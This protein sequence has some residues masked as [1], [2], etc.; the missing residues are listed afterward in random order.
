MNR[1]VGCKIDLKGRV[2]K[3]KE[4]L[5]VLL[6]FSILTL[7]SVWYFWRNPQQ[8]AFFALAVFIITLFVVMLASRRKLLVVQ[9]TLHLLVG[10]FK[11]IGG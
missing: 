11:Q 1:T 6:F 9:Y 4:W 2:Q 8:I 10:V 5:W 7:Y 3:Y